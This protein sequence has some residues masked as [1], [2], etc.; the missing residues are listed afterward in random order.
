MKK[1][2]S[3]V[4]IVG[5]GVSGLYAALCLAELQNVTDVLLVTKSTLKESNSRYAQGGIVAVLPENIQDS[6]NLHVKDTLK[7]GA[8]LTDF[9]SAKFVSEQSSDVINDLIKKGVPFDRDENN[10]ISLTLEAAHSVRR[11]LHSGGDATGR[12]IESTLADLVQNN[13]KIKIETNTIV[14]ELLLNV[15]NA[16]NGAILFNE[17]NNEYTAVFSNSVIIATGGL[18]QLYKHTTNPKI[19]TADGIALAYQANAFIQDIEFVQFHPTAMLVPNSDNMFLISESVRGEGAR[20]RNKNNELFAFKY[21]PMADL[22]P[23]DVVARAIYFET[24]ETNSDN[25][26]L[27]ATIIENNRLKDRFP[28]IYKTCIDNGIDIDNDFIPVSPAAHYS[29]GGIK[30]DV[31]GLTNVEGLYA[32]GEVACTG[33]HGANRLASNSLLECIAGSKKLAEIVSEKP[34]LVSCE[35][36]SVQSQIDK[37]DE[38]SSVLNIDVTVLKS[39]IQKIMWDYAG[40]IRSEQLLLTGLSQLSNLKNKLEKIEKFDT[41]EEYE[42]RN[43]LIVS[44]LIIK[45]ALSRK[46]SRGAHY[47]SDYTSASTIAC[48][49]QIKKGDNES[50]LTSCH[51]I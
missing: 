14:V 51:Y 15:D 46:E 29:M 31:Y 1:S 32:I 20:L 11:I 26:F 30:T 8:G 28:N 17:N 34:I 42:L 12:N 50:C 23:R 48:H 39:E 47:R 21:H 10:N 36:I 41:I 9:D 37:Y 49:S 38:I 16:C 24:K 5:S 40:I 22:A 7:A 45:S 13:P 44:E 4:I 25:V 19:A 18:G 35:D 3:Q 2:N 27:D 43:M 33:L 6:V